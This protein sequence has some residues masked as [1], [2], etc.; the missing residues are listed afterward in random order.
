MRNIHK[1]THTH[2]A[3]LVTLF[4]SSSSQDFLTDLA[5]FLEVEFWQGMQPVGQL[6]EVEKLHLKPEL[7]IYIQTEVQ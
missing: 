3:Y 7:E 2:T 4:N 5:N 1:L 6:S